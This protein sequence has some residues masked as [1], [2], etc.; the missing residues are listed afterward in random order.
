MLLQEM[1]SFGEKRIGQSAPFARSRGVIEIKEIL[2]RY[3]VVCVPCAYVLYVRRFACLL[4]DSDTMGC[5]VM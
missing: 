1:S 4:P 3:D 2:L 5:D